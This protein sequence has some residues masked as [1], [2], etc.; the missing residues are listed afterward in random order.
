MDG[1][2][3]VHGQTDADLRSIASSTPPR[4]KPSSGSPLSWTHSVEMARTCVWI[5]RGW[6]ASAPRRSSMPCLA[7]WFIAVRTSCHAFPLNSR[8]GKSIT[9]S[10]ATWIECQPM[11]VAWRDA[12]EVTVNRHGTS[13]AEW[14]S[15]AKAR[16]RSERCDSV[17]ATGSHSPMAT[18]A[19]TR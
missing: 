8:D 11:V 7:A 9:A 4:V 6:S 17:L 5:P 16:S 2:V 18:P 13:P 15:S 19:W 10:S 12:S 1:R 3:G 14:T